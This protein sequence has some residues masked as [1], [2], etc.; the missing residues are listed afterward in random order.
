MSLWGES[1]K[2]KLKQWTKLWEECF[3]VEL[4]RKLRLQ[5][6]HMGDY[7]SRRPG[8]RKAPVRMVVRIAKT[9]R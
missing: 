7:T 3:I 9:F 2:S 5:H 8:Y 1:W 4:V 6:V